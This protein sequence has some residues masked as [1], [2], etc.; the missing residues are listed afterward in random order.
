MKKIKNGCNEAAKPAVFMVYYGVKAALG[1]LLIGIFAYIYNEYIFLGGFNSREFCI[2]VI[3]AA[4][5]L[6]VQ[7]T[8]GGIIFDVAWR[9]NKK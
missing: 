3:Q 4:V 2:G 1:V 6:F 5:S 9:K 8:A 7:F